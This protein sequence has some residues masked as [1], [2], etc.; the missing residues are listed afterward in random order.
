MPLAV[1]CDVLRVKDMGEWSVERDA[2]TSVFFIDSCNLLETKN[3]EA[4]AVRILKCDF[5]EK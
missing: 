4:F 1:I 5:D 3:I 2:S